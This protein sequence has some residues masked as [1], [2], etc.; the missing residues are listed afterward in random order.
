MH[1]FLS[2]SPHA[3]RHLALAGPSEAQRHHQSYLSG[4][5]DWGNISLQGT[6]SVYQ[7]LSRSGML[8]LPA[9]CN[10]TRRAADHL[11]KVE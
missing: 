4:A 11:V 2:N 5:A 10:L 9:C 1:G 7:Y 8:L 6:L 3:R